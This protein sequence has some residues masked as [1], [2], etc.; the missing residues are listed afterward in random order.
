ME[1]YELFWY[2]TA[3]VAN[4]VKNVEPICNMDIGEHLGT[5]IIKADNSSSGRV[6]WNMQEYIENMSGIAYTIPFSVDI[7]FSPESVLGELNT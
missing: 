6:G 7:S 2:F 3:K 4:L 5:R 1:I